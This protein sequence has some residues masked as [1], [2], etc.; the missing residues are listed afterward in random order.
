MTKYLLRYKLGRNDETSFPKY[1]CP[2]SL[3]MLY[4]GDNMRQNK[5]TDFT[6]IFVNVFPES[7]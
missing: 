1:V 6:I 2:F 4:F 5:L 3:E 7:S